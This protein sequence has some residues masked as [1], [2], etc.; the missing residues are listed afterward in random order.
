MENS[1]NTSCRTC[2]GTLELPI[3]LFDAKY[4]D[5]LDMLQRFL[6]FQVYVPQYEFNICGRCRGNLKWMIDFYNTCISSLAQLHNTVY[7]RE[8]SQAID[9]VVVKPE[10]SSFPL[11]NDYLPQAVPRIITRSLKTAEASA[12]N[13]RNIR[14][15][16]RKLPDDSEVSSDDSENDSKKRET[17]KSEDSSDADDNPVDELSEDSSESSDNEEERKVVT[18]KPKRRRS[19]RYKKYPTNQVLKAI[20]DAR[21]HLSNM[22]S[23]QCLLCDY[24]GATSTQ[25]RKHFTTIHPEHLPK[26]C[27]FCNLIF[28]DLEAHKTSSEDCSYRCR[29]CGKQAT[30][31]SNLV[32]HLKFHSLEQKDEF[33]V[34]QRRQMKLKQFSANEVNVAVLDCDLLPPVSYMQG[35]SKLRKNCVVCNQ[36]GILGR[37]LVLHMNTL[38]K[39]VSS[40]WCQFCNIL[41]DNLLEHEEEGLC[42]PLRC[43]FCRLSFSKLYAL[44]THL[45]QHCVKNE[46]NQLL[47]KGNSW[48]KRTNLVQYPK[49][50]VQKAL[51]KCKI[52]TTDLKYRTCLYCNC[53]VV[54]SRYLVC[55]MKRLHRNRCKNWCPRCNTQ[56][57]DLRRHLKSTKCSE[58]KCNFCKG[59]FSSVNNLIT[60]L[61]MHCVELTLQEE[62][63]NSVP[64]QTDNKETV[65]VLPV[66]ELAPTSSSVASDDSNIFT[67]YPMPSE[68]IT[69]NIQT[70]NESLVPKISTIRSG[71]ESNEKNS[72]HT[73]QPFPKET[74]DM[75]IAELTNFMEDAKFKQCVLCSHTM[76]EYSFLRG[77]MKTKH[78]KDIQNWCADCN[79][80]TENLKAHFAAVK[81]NERKC[82]LCLK[83]YPSYRCIRRHMINHYHSDDMPNP[84]RNI[85]PMCGKNFK[86]L[87]NHINSVH[88]NIGKSFK[89]SYCGKMFKTITLLKGHEKRHTSQKTIPC[90]FCEKTFANMPEKKSHLRIHEGG[91]V[92]CTICYQVLPRP[93][94]LKLHMRRH[95]GENR[96]Q[97]NQCEKSYHV[98]NLLESHMVTHSNERPFK[99]DVCDK[100]FKI[101]QT[102]QKHELTHKGDRPFKCTFC[103][104]SA[105]QSHALTVHMKTHPEDAPLASKPHKCVFCHLSFSTN[106]VL[107]SHTEYTHGNGRE[108]GVKKINLPPSKD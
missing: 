15:I 104:F 4:N 97:C 92:Q 76:N 83:I 50:K 13:K 30:T 11:N 99:C 7:K 102:L 23:T 73:V 95:T 68:D 55:H 108:R 46:L 36:K 93:G 41:T 72:T 8:E 61:K 31:R 39:D 42:N 53:I 9:E 45:R 63:G 106:A 51:A 32:D 100:R 85:C 19:G 47:L 64:N 82:A 49:D 60:H 81:C 35:R 80:I 14:K 69:N 29:F 24:I 88:S 56:T 86:N 2:L 89:C 67:P 17:T 33:E 98:K 62:V 57:E 52:Y 34:L 38:H 5:L 25:L 59:C 27:K 21:R 103:N 91:P 75:A 28:D 78:K 54:A 79:L 66:P 58:N 16:S 26:F 48:R 74:V 22:R 40:K 37:R 3:N 18:S 77:H 20:K 71:E 65:V 44:K 101:L 70:Q 1:N 84:T 12:T 107:L 94:V 90:D 96:F 105:V 43:K 87:S 10:I 6:A